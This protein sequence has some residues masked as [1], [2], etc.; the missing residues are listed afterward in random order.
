MVHPRASVVAVRGIEV[1][2]R[3]L[4]RVTDEAHIV[5]VFLTLLVWP[6]V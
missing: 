2:G 1:G 6:K 4:A 5:Q 3:A